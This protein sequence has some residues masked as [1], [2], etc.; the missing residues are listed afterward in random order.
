MLY[1][2]QLHVPSSEIPWAR[3]LGSGIGIVAPD[4]P[5]DG[6]LKSLCMC[7][8]VSLVAL[9][10]LIFTLFIG[11]DSALRSPKGSALQKRPWPYDKGICWGG[12]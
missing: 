12:Y 1:V 6:L 9:F 4:F 5:F 10:I 8:H 7:F 2:T 11:I 3:W